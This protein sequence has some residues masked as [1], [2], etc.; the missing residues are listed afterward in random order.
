MQINSGIH[1]ALMIFQNQIMSGWHIFPSR[2]FLSIMTNLDCFVF[3]GNYEANYQYIIYIT[4]V[5]KLII[6]RTLTI[7]LNK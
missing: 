6:V 7:D 3:E 5:S 4:F 1:H 2:N